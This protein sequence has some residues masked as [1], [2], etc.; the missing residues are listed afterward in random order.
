MS[1][2]VNTNELNQESNVAANSDKVSFLQTAEFLSG[3]IV[4]LTRRIE[5]LEATLQP[6]APVSEP[7]ADPAVNPA[8]EPT[9]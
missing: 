1:R 7:P 5:S 2:N 3:Q 4:E 9:I 8:P 6:A